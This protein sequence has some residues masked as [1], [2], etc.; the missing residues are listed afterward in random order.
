MVARSRFRTLGTFGIEPP[1]V[2]LVPIVVEDSGAFGPFPLEVLRR[3]RFGRWRD[4]YHESR[5]QTAIAN[6]DYRQFPIAELARREEARLRTEYVSITPPSERVAHAIRDLDA[7]AAL[8]EASLAILASGRGSPIAVQATSERL[9]NAQLI[10][11]E[12]IRSLPVAPPTA[13]FPAPASDTAPPP[14]GLPPVTAPTPPFG[15]TPAAEPSR[16]ST[17]ARELLVA[18]LL[19]SPALVTLLVLNLPKRSRRAG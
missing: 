10:L 12:A 18:G 17:G 15:T 11:D 1:E 2:P 6:A 13:S 7:A 8:R 19:L 4:A 9:A 5:R 16:R 3:A 14:I